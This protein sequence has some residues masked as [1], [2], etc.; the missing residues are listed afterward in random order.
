MADTD[1]SDKDKPDNHVLMSDKP[2]KDKPDKDKPDKR[3]LRSRKSVSPPVLSPVYD[4]RRMSTADEGKS[5]CSEVSSLDEEASRYIVDS[6]IELR[7]PPS[8]VIPRPPSQISSIC[9]PSSQLSEGRGE[10]G[11]IGSQMSLSNLSN[12]VPRTMSFGDGMGYPRLNSTSMDMEPPGW[13]R[14]EIGSS[15]SPGLVE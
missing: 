2:D 11:A 3:I 15:G 7:V 10:F 8:R 4:E 5:E 13:D 6:T 12:R 9:D 14:F 1:N